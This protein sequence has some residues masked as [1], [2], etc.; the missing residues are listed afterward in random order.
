MKYKIDD[1]GKVRVT[2]R[3]GDRKTSYT[4]CQ[5]FNY[6]VDLDSEQKEILSKIIMTN[7]QKLNIPNEDINRIISKGLNDL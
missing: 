3:I 6:E 7:L 4:T 5:E 1:S 2:F